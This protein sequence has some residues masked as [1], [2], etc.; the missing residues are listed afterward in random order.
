MNG[1]MWKFVVFNAHLPRNLNKT[2]DFF[3]TFW[4]FIQVIK[5]YNSCT[6]LTYHGDVKSVYII[7]SNNNLCKVLSSQQVSLY[8]DVYI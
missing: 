4:A 5:V 6:L 8:F 3:V 7:H 2:S 1:R